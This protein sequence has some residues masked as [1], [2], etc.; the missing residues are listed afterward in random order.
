M[1]V[2]E[3][4]Y[5]EFVQEAIPLR[6]EQLDH[7]IENPGGASPTAARA[8]IKHFHTMKD[9]LPDPDDPYFM[10][11]DFKNEETHYYGYGTLASGIGEIPKTHTGVGKYLVRHRDMDAT[12]VTAF[13]LSDL[14]DVL[15]RIRITIK[16]GELIEIGKPEMIE[17][18]NISEVPQVIASELLKATMSETRGDSL[19]AVGSTLQPD[20]FRITR[21]PDDVVLSL[22]GPPG[23][24]KTIVLLERLSRIAF[25]DPIARKNGILLI[26]PNETFLEYVESAL[27]QLGKADT[28]TKTVE[29][30]TKWKY[31]KKPDHDSIQIIKASLNFQKIID[32][33]ISEL[34]QIIDKDFTFQIKDVKVTYSVHESFDLINSLRKEFVSYES[35]KER[36]SNNILAKLSE[37][38]LSQKIEIG[39]QFTRGQINPEAT[40][41]QQASFKNMLKIMFPEISPE[42]ILKDIKT[43]SNDFFRLASNLI[44]T[45]DVENWLKHVISEPYEI[46][47][48]DIPILD[49]I[50]FRL[51]GKVD[52]LWGY[53]A[54]DEAQ[55]LTPMQLS[56]LSRRLS[57]S[58]AITLTGD[59]A[60]AIGPI[61]YETWAEIVGIFDSNK[62][63]VNRELTRS[64]RVPKDLISFSTQFL[65]NSNVEVKPAE[66][67]LDIKDA[68]QIVETESKEKIEF[69]IHTAEKHL[70]DNESVLVLG[71]KK[72][73]AEIHHWQP[74]ITG[75]AHLKKYEV[76]EVKGLEFDVVIIVD[77]IDLLLEMNYDL[78]RT[79]R[80]LYVMTTRAT[81]RLYLIGPN[82]EELQNLLQTYHQ[83][84]YGVSLPKLEKYS[85]RSN[86]QVLPETNDY[87]E[88]F[89]NTRTGIPI[90]CKQFNLEISTTDSQF[91]EA[92]WTYR[93]LTQR[94]CYECASKPQLFF[95]RI[96]SEYATFF[97]MVCTRC[98]TIRGND[99]YEDDTLELVK[100][101]LGLE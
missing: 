50:Q 15:R 68:L 10:R 81:K 46:R 89:T 23:S 73:L 6:A 12:G 47:K 16:N 21:A 34:P 1:Y 92:D 11:I 42:K 14:P 97:A 53:I 86:D 9:A 51:I 99:F 48:E 60:Q 39:P 41:K 38:Y 33:Y 45:E 58:G 2:T 98:L 19:S 31:S 71:S 64:Y 95:Q 88:E 13:S 4:S 69:L 5:L 26:G 49:Y 59:L 24:G 54:I 17:T 66:P 57:K 84:K 30:L 40:I 7:Y 22:Q 76:T 18:A 80:L 44:E 43:K 91:L 77:P 83:M 72:F 78:G 82:Q 65:E 74:E 63:A 87:Q 29:G 35:T 75:K 61:F 55:N 37:K 70:E 56:M 52:K 79:A 20:Q 28:K 27:S 8:L 101:E 36:A 3:A 93:G 94:R 96:T 25:K 100:E 62:N 67:F 32:N 90:L 85:D